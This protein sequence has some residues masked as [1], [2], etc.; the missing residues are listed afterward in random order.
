MLQYVRF[1]IYHFILNSTYLLNLLF[2]L[3]SN[4]IYGKSLRNGQADQRAVG[5]G[6]ASEKENPGPKSEALSSDEASFD[7]KVPSFYTKAH[8]GTGTSISS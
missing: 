3:Q 2:L 8:D 4:T 6:G 5:G 7:P 1:L